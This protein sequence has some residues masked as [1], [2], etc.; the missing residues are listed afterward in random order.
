MILKVIRLSAP[1]DASAFFSFSAFKPPMANSSYERRW[2]LSAAEEKAAFEW[3]IDFVMEQWKSF[4]PMH[5]YHFGHKEPS[6]LKALM[7]RYVTR[8]DEIDRMLRAG[9]L[10]P[11]LHHE[12]IRM[13]KR[14]SKIRLKHLK[15]F[16]ASS[17]PSRSTKLGPPCG[18]W[19]M[20]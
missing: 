18:R 16:M 12:A 10:V 13:R 6:T 17:E 8:E 11:P 15:N 19:S 20:H 5:I 2:A 14:L 9:V 7:G 4:P 3:F 1:T